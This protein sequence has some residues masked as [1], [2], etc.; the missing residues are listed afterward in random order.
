MMDRHAAPA[1][2]SDHDAL[3]QFVV[4]NEDLLEL[5]RH[6]G[7]FNIFDALRISRTEIRH[8]NFLAWL[9]DPAESHGC[10]AL[11][12]NAVL[13]DL[14]RQTP[15]ELRPISPIKLDGAQLSGVEVRR[16]WRNI[17]LLI[18]SRDP[19]FVIAIENKIGAGESRGQLMRYER[20]VRDAF[21]KVPSLF[22]FLTP[23]GEDASEDTWTPYSYE[24]LHATLERLRATGTGAIGDEVSTFLNHY[25]RLLRSRVMEDETIAELCQR[26]Y[27]NHRQAIDLIIEHA[28]T[29]GSEV[30]S[31]VREILD[32]Q[33]DR[34]C[35]HNQ[36]GSLIEF[37]PKAWLDILPPIGSRASKDEQ[38]WLTM[39]FVVAKS[40]HRIVIG[41]HPVTDSEARNNIV[42][43]FRPFYESRATKAFKATG[44]SDW[45]RLADLWSSPRTEAQID[46]PEAIHA[47]LV[48]EFN[49]LWDRWKDS[50][51]PL[52]SAIETATLNRAQS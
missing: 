3:E 14:L 46:D 8:S 42:A 5:E 37:M 9:L 7:R 4:D 18:H 31:I 33:P 13:I 39:R 40:E 32:A 35:T 30:L 51:A 24:S 19:S 41:T 22:V 11:F 26:I 27:K 29:G 49:R 47:T 16:E 25:T 17:D 6:I 45:K 23:A 15:R 21:P 12:L 50:Q 38:T 2:P 10:G 43:K 1:P 52:Q 48:T 36:T 28:A 34:W 44:K 20:T